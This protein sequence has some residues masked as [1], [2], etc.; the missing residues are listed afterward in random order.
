MSS[1]P[2]AIVGVSAEFPSGEE[3]NLDYSAYWPF[4]LE[5]REA[6]GPIPDDRFNYDA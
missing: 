6:Y 2:I 3:E 5:R 4:L 1:A